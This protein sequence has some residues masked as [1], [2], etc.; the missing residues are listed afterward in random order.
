M[1][2]RLMDLAHKALQARKPEACHP[3]AS[4]KHPPNTAS[5]GLAAHAPSSPSTP[6]ESPGANSSIDKN[7]SNS[8]HN[9]N[10]NNDNKDIDQSNNDKNSS[11]NSNSKSNNLSSS[12]SP[13]QTQ[14]TA[15]AA[16][17]TCIPGQEDSPKRPHVD[18]E[19]SEPTSQGSP[20][21]PHN[22]TEEDA[23]QHT[24][25]AAAAHQSQD[26]PPTPRI[27]TEE[28]ALQHKCAAAHQSQDSPPTLRIQT[29]EDAL[30][31]KHE[32]AAA[33]KSQDRPPSPHIETEEDALQRKREAAAAQPQHRLWSALAQVTAAAQAARQSTAR[34]N[35]S[36]ATLSAT[37][38]QQQQGDSQQPKPT[39]FAATQQQHPLTLALT[40]E[41][42]NAGP[43]TTPSHHQ[44]PAPSA[45]AGASCSSRLPALA[46]SAW[47]GLSA[48][49][50]Y[51]PSRWVRG[52]G[53]DSKP[54]SLDHT[55]QGQDGLSDGGASRVSTARAAATREA[56]DTQQMQQSHTRTP[57]PTPPASTARRHGPATVPSGPGSGDEKREAGPRTVR[58]RIHV[59]RGAG[60]AGNPA[61]PLLLLRLEVD[62]RAGSSSISGRSS[63]SNG[64]A[65]DL[66]ARPSSSKHTA[67]K[68]GSSPD[69]PA[70]RA[71]IWVLPGMCQCGRTAAQHSSSVSPGSPRDASSMST[72]ALAVAHSPVSPDPPGDACSV[73]AAAPASVAVYRAQ[74]CPKAGSQAQLEGQPCDSTA[75]QAS[76]TAA[77]SQTQLSTQPEGQQ[78]CAPA[79]AYLAGSCLCCQPQ[80]CLQQCAHSSSA[81]RAAAHTQQQCTHSSRA[82]TAAVRAPQHAAAQTAATVHT[83]Q[84][85]THSSNAHTAAVQAQRD[86]AAQGRPSPEPQLLQ[87]SLEVVSEAPGS[88]NASETAAAEKDEAAAH[89]SLYLHGQRLYG[90]AASAA[91]YAASVAAQAAASRLPSSQWGQFASHYLSHYLGA[92][93]AHTSS[94]QAPAPPTSVTEAGS[95]PGRPSSQSGPME[96]SGMEG[97]PGAQCG[98]EGLRAGTAGFEECTANGVLGT[99][100][101]AGQLQQGLPRWS[102]LGSRDGGKNKAPLQQQQGGGGQA[103][104]KVD[105]GEEEEGLGEMLEDLRQVLTQPQSDCSPLDFQNGSGYHGTQAAHPSNGSGMDVSSRGMQ[106]I[107][108]SHC[109]AGDGAVVEGLRWASHAQ[110]AASQQ[111]SLQSR[112]DDVA[113]R[114]PSAEPCESSPSDPLC[115]GPNSSSSSG[116]SRHQ[117]SA[118]QQ[119]LPIEAVKVVGHSQRANSLGE[120]YT[121]YEMEVVAEPGEDGA[122]RS[123][124]VARRFSDFV[125]LKRTLMP[126]LGPPS[127]SSSSSAAAQPQG[128]GHGLPPCWDEL[129]QGRSVLG[130][131][132]FSSHASV[133]A[134]SHSESLTIKLVTH[135]VPVLPEGQL[136]AQ[137]AGMCAGCKGPLPAP[138][139][140]AARMSWSWSNLRAG[141]A[142]AGGARVCWYTGGLFCSVCHANDVRLIPGRVLHKWDLQPRPVCC[143]AAEFLSEVSARPVLCVSAINPDLL[144]R[145]A[146]LARAQYLR[147]E[148]TRNLQSAVGSGGGRASRAEQIVQAAGLRGYLLSGHLGDFWALDDLSEL[149]KGALSGLLPWLEGISRDVSKL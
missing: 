34:S 71:R 99:T 143:A 40:A 60:T 86:A 6:N 14:T 149:S 18:P 89:S 144:R 108:R 43:P 110:Q 87:L 131:M 10:K 98:K 141:S 68:R 7:N 79:Q 126:V 12:T 44:P 124:R 26:S 103:G 67:K 97:P 16:A 46:G 116:S 148:A 74:P 29:E 37:A 135:V 33:H 118:H 23:L 21:A 24:C 55:Q 128:S 25:E 80:P 5:P 146:P 82:H 39:T 45:T 77:G 83:L 52:G 112:G 115:G 2:Q 136:L 57:P 27:E 19:Y 63:C 17:A 100:A 101:G 76:C 139:P 9:E 140:A 122:H 145:V 90:S 119:P 38:T 13:G 107:S 75:S 142:G 84:Q 104:E 11:N 50:A 147:Q 109:A 134:S 69:L 32:V 53:E 20:P 61:L 3:D 31:H 92:H 51:V 94:P 114:V 95:S 56:R 105:E 120:T 65:N 36:T 102:V 42:S 132:R 106:H 88:R 125:Q 133:L 15:P 85:C 28:D 22:E 96:A 66:Q 138:A 35:P 58:A 111:G 129:S 1:A 130:Q 48:V 93:N 127:N 72:A 78:V 121:L 4:Q 64:G 30:L 113:A 49:S 91:A 62:E 73:S 59:I 54:G 81:H 117:G 70:V 47:Q 8:S 41:P 137:Q 123:W